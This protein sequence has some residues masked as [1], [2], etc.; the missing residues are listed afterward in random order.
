MN[1]GHQESSGCACRPGEPHVPGCGISAW[2]ALERSARLEQIEDVN[3]TFRALEGKARVVLGVDPAAG[4]EAV[5]TWA[6][7][8]G[9]DTPGVKPV[10]LILSEKERTDCE[11]FASALRKAIEEY[12]RQQAEEARIMAEF[13]PC[14]KKC[15]GLHDKDQH[16]FPLSAPDVQGGRVGPF[17]VLAMILAAVALGWALLGR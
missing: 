12:N 5:S 9:G 6:I 17:D 3:G 1:G 10:L 4:P 7:L 8:V 16:S 11:R 2:A 15:N 14:T 13:Q